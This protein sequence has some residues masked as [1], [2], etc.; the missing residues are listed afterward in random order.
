[1][2]HWNRRR[3]GNKDV[4]PKDALEQKHFGTKDGEAFATKFLNSL[5][6]ME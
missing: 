5:Q 2:T 1:M 6:V 4:G 3:I